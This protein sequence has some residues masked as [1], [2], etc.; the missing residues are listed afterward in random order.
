MIC[1][2][3]LLQVVLSSIHFLNLKAS[4]GPTN[5][6]SNLSIKLWES[7]TPVL[8]FLAPFM[9]DWGRWRKAGI[10]A[11]GG[12]IHLWEGLYHGLVP[13]SSL[14]LKA[15]R[16]GPDSHPVLLKLLVLWVVQDTLNGV[17]QV[18][19]RRPVLGLLWHHL[20]I[21]GADGLMWRVC[22]ASLIRFNSSV[23][24]S[25]DARAIRQGALLDLLIHTCTTTGPRSTALHR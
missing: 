8:L 4:S 22:R 6:R 12:W 14:I 19:I 25:A 13:S 5:S 15:S 21:P 17:G 20:F 1:Q 2:E 9:C 16:P 3:N 18:P 23:A 24:L 10:S 7:H 11:Y